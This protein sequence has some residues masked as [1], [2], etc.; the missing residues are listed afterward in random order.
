MRVRV[1]PTAQKPGRKIRLFSYVLSGKNLTF[2]QN[3]FDLTTLS[4]DILTIAVKEHGAELCS[5]RKGETEYFWQADPAFWARHSPVLFPIVGSVWEG[6]FRVGGSEY[7]MGQHLGYFQVMA[8]P[9]STC[10]QLNLLST[11]LQCPRLVTKL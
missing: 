5:I 8:E 11:P 3:H 9:V 7:K 10:V 1:S 2:T 6:T 4:N